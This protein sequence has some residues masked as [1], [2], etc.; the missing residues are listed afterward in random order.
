MKIFGFYISRTDWKTIAMS[1][2]R[3]LDK[4][5]EIVQRNSEKLRD[6]QDIV[7]RGE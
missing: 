1:R 5:N 6:I 3:M 4:Y 7:R 2:A